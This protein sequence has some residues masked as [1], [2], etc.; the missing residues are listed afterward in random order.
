M[1]VNNSPVFGE[2]YNWFVLPNFSREYD[3]MP[4]NLFWTFGDSV[5]FSISFDQCLHEYFIVNAFAMV[6]LRFSF[7]QFYL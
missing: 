6:K 5:Y 3:L 1:Q 7:C 2:Y 4:F